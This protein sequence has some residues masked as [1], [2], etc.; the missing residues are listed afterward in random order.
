M[1]SSLAKKPDGDSE[2]MDGGCMM[3]LGRFVALLTPSR[4]LDLED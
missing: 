4:E 1:S 3:S 2:I